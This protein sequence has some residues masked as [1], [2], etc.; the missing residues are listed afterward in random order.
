MALDFLAGCAGGA[1]AGAECGEAP[2]PRDPAL[3]PVHRQAGKC[4][5]P[6]QG[7][8][9]AAHGAHLHQCAGVRGTGKHPP[10]PGPGLATEPVPG[11]RC[12]GCHPV[13]HL[14][15]HGAGQDTAAAAGRGPGPHLQGLPGLPGADLPPRGCAW[16]Q[17]GHGVHTAA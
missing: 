3:L 6:V 10:G 11:R 13:C 8:G 12:C 4:A 14:L 5:R 17:P 7:P 15:P 9:L 2:V 16:H 1:A